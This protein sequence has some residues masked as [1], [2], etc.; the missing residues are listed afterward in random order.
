M[1]IY[2]QIRSTSISEGIHYPHA[3]TYEKNSCEFSL[4]KYIAAE[5]YYVGS[6]A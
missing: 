5:G 6:R 3:H 1:S 2:M 4:L